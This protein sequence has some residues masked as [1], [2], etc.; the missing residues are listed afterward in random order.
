VSEPAPEILALAREEA[1]ESLARIESSLLALESGT[2]EPDTLD[3]LFRDAHSIK[4]AASMVGMSDVAAIAHAM[5]DRLER[6]RHHGELPVEL[7]EPLLAAADAVRHALDG[8]EVD[9]SSVVEWLGTPA[10]APEPPSNGGARPAAPEPAQ[11]QAAPAAIRVGAQKVDRMLD[12]VGETVLH[13]RRLEHELG[14]MAEGELDMGERLLTELQQSVLAMRTVPLH[15]IT[16]RYRRAVRDLAV[17]SGL[18]VELEIAGGETQLDRLIL[19][20]IADPLAHLIRN[21]VAH[22]IEPPEERERAGKPRQGTVRLAGEQRGSMVAIEVSDDGRG[23]SAEVLARAR[24]AGSLTDLLSAPGFSTASEVSDIAGRGV[25]LDAVRKQVERMGGSIEV[26]SEPS[27]GMRVTLLLPLTLALMKVLVCERGGQAFGLPMGSVREVT[28]VTETTSLSGRPSIVIRGEPVPVTD[29]ADALGAAAPE[30]P[31]SPPALV[32]VAP[33]GAMAVACDSV[34]GDEE[35]VTKSLG[36]LLAGTPGYLGAAILGNGQVVLIL[37]PSHLLSGDRRRRTELTPLAEPESRR[38]APRVLVVDDQFTVRELQ[39]SIL[40]TAGYQVQV[41]RD[42]REALERLARDSRIDMVLTDVQMP[43]MD[44][45]EL[46]REIR[47]DNASLPV[48]IVTSMAAE[49]DKRRGVEEG[50]DAYIVKQD[51]DQQALLETIGR[52]VGR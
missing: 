19:E 48:V 23:T 17:A 49:E 7:V 21:S 12:A 32:L 30:L 9:L 31:E 35:V 25:G 3:A 26:S 40:E 1:G 39:R 47:R 2:P 6:C 16:G 36:P 42:G 13:H 50:A 28:A 5:E 10:P 11:P 37:D 27:R 43:N 15:S 4:G 51:F 33:S 45:F 14:G 20:G 46:L 24:E 38:E 8:E 52:L 18:E 41:A 44:G 22:G 29:L 34:L